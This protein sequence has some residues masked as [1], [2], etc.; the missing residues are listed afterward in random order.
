[1]AGKLLKE[2]KR[3]GGGKEKKREEGGRQAGKRHLPPH[4]MFLKPMKDLGHMD[5]NLVAFLKRH[6]RP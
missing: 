2:R 6:Q 5:Q 4:F 3:G 1:M